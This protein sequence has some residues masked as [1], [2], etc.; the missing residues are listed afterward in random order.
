MDERCLFLKRRLNWERVLCPKI[1]RFM[2][3]VFFPQ[4]LIPLCGDDNPSLEIIHRLQKNLEILLQS[5]TR[6]ASRS[7][8]LGS[9]HQVG[10]L[11]RVRIITI[12]SA[13]LFPYHVI[14]K[15]PFERFEKCKL[16]LKQGGA[17]VFGST[18]DA[19]PVHKHHKPYVNTAEIV[20]VFFYLLFIYNTILKL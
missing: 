8:M 11:Q 2:V 5:V 10:L 16:S 6:V 14:W 17:F 12:R 13:W 4:A 3:A 20:V 19:L 18:T 7:E 15:I 9:I 1:W